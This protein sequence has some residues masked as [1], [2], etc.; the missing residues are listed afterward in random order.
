MTEKRKIVEK[1]IAE[2]RDVLKKFEK[3]I[4]SQPHLPQNMRKCHRVQILIKDDKIHISFNSF[5]KF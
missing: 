5:Q 4:A 2:Y 3:W 1:I